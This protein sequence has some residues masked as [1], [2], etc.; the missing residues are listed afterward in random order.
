[1]ERASAG[2]EPPLDPRLAG[3]IDDLGPNRWAAFA[4][5]ARQR[6]VWVSDELKAFLGEHDD[7][8][9][10][11]GEHILVAWQDPV[12]IGS[13]TPDSGATL[14]LTA[15]RYLRDLGIP[16]DVL[17]T[18][19]DE[20]RQY[21]ASLPPGGSS[22]LATAS[23]DYVEKDLPPY[24]V[25]CVMAALRA[26]DGE[27][28]GA[29]AFT[30]VGLR[31][32]LLAL[33]GRGDAS[34][35][36]RMA[37]IAEPGRHATAILFAD[38]EASGQ[39]SRALPTATYFALIRDLTSAFDRVVAGNGGIAGKHVGD[40]W[41]A[42]IL[43]DEA[44][45]P[46]GAVAAAI[47]IARELQAHA[48]QLTAAWTLPAGLPIRINAAVHWGPGVY[49]GQLVPGGRLDVTALGDEVNEC[50]RV[51]ECAR[52]G[53]VLV[54]KEAMELLDHAAL[55][56]LGVGVAQLVYRPLVSMEGAGEKTRRDAASVAVVA[57]TSDGVVTP[58]SH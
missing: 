54:T 35:Y 4:L 32:T 46:P 30:N 8:R 5:D 36:E 28:L 37:R 23:I 19:P 29:V 52:G 10:R 44:G 51:E 20:S 11:V 16:D 15:L 9:L 45:G 24:R 40:G 12:W 3:V 49:L 34:M 21:L 42:F 18:L 58:G 50:A 31:P 57:V 6:L 56:R 47:T 1:M 2:Q 13:L 43:A 53:A 33:L 25:E 7:R 55:R 22:P 17:A 41:T 14:F 27:L 39:L 26:E 38:M 48:A